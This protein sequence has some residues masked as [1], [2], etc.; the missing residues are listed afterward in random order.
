MATICAAIILFSLCACVIYVAYVLQSA[1]DHARAERKAQAIEAEREALE[2]ELEDAKA[3]HNL[4]RIALIRSKLRGLPAQEQ[5]SL[6][7]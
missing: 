4:A 1:R 6:R 7:G 3:S 5:D 2:K